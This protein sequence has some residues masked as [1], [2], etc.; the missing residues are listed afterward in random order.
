MSVFKV[1]MSES[2]FFYKQNPISDKLSKRK[3]NLKLPVTFLDSF[4]M[5]LSLFHQDLLS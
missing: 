5:K 2:R 3:E 4:L 1:I